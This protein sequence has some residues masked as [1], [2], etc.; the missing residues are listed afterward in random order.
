MLRNVGSHFRL[1]HK[2]RA[3]LGKLT[4][5]RTSTYAFFKQKSS[6]KQFRNSEAFYVV[7]SNIYI[8]EKIVEK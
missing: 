4:L 5:G 8:K 3:T 1:S 2:T 6:L 7:S